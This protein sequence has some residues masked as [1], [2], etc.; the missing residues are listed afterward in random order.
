MTGPH[1]RIIGMRSRG[2]PAGSAFAAGPPQS[3]SVDFAACGHAAGRLPRTVFGG[4]CMHLHTR[5][6]GRRGSAA[7][8]AS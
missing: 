2:P 8:Q 4:T 6:R 3:S 7:T 5:G 1:G